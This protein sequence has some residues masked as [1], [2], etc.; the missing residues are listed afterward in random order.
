MVEDGLVLF[1]QANAG[2]NAIVSTPAYPD[3][4]PSGSPLPNYSYVSV[5]KG[6]LYGLQA[7]PGLTQWRVQIDCFS[8]TDQGT[9]AGQYSG[10]NSAD[11][12]LAVF[13]ALSGY[14]GVF[15]DPQHT[16]VDSAFMIDWNGPK[17]DAVRRTFHTMVEFR[18]WYIWS[19]PI[20]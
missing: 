4:L 14:K 2:V 17:F 10:A 7:Q 5:F 8:G 6:P 3:Y 19:S 1:L 11:L 12:A 20:V 13:N 9:Q 18:I 15:P 16:Q